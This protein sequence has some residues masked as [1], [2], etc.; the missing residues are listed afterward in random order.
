MFFSIKDEAR[1][2]DAVV[3]G[4]EYEGAGDRY[5]GAGGRILYYCTLYPDNCT[6]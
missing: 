3:R 1:K 6:L 4:Q 5:Q 2:K